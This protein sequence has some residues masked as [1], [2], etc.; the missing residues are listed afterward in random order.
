MSGVWLG[1]ELWMKIVKNI[2]FKVIGLRAKHLST[3]LSSMG[4]WGTYTITTW[5]RSFLFLIKN[6]GS[7]YEFNW[8][9]R[10]CIR[11]WF[12]FTKSTTTRCTPNTNTK[13]CWIKK[14]IALERS[15]PSTYIPHVHSIRA[16]KK[17]RKKE[18]KDACYPPPARIVVTMST[19]VLV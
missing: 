13:R 16:R 6:N 4:A 10:K 3:I 17:G 19:I 12:G 1:V 8:L 15:N 18:R 5:E 7:L 11:A 2:C 9:Q 14:N